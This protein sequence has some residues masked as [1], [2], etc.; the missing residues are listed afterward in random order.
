V[1]TGRLQVLP[2]LREGER[3]RVKR[4]GRMKLL[5]FAFWFL[6]VQKKNPDG[7]RVKPPPF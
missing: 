2:S 5:P 3:E 1:A 4:K 7:D 6:I